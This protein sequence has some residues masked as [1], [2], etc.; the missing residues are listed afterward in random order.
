[1]VFWG[2]EYRIGNQETWKDTSQ[3]FLVKFQQLDEHY[4]SF[5]FVF[6]KLVATTGGL[7]WCGYDEKDELEHLRNEFLSKLPF[8]VETTKLN[9]IIHTTVARYKNKLNN[10]QKILDYVNSHSEKVSMRVKAI[11]LKTELVFPSIKTEKIAQINLQ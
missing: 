1:M 8:P 11:V 2:G 7:I 3:D 10:P 9:H 6:S 5:E 4:S